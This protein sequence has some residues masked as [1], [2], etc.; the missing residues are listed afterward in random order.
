MTLQQRIDEEQSKC[1]D[2]YFAKKDAKEVIPR[3]HTLRAKT[4]YSGLCPHCGTY[5]YGDCQS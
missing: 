4:N 5:C 1:R 3:K 2:E